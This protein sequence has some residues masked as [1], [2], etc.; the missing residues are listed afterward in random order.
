M[1]SEEL[2][3][4]NLRKVALVL[5]AGHTGDN[6]KPDREPKN[7]EFIFGIAVCGIT[8]FEKM[9]YQKSAGDEVITTVDLRNAAEY[10]GP[11]AAGILNWLPERGELALK[12]GIAAVSTP[13]DREIVKALA[14]GGGCGGSCD[15]GC[16]GH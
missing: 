6:F 12:V 5:E 11:L 14:A 7:V 15:C 8:P 2:A 3:V 10:F 1:Q 16:G 13:E 4:D 9:L